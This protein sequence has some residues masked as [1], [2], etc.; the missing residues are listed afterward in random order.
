LGQIEAF[1]DNLVEL[2]MKDLGFSYRD[3]HQEITVMGERLRMCRNIEDLLRVRGPICE[4]NEE[5][6]LALSYNGSAWLNIVIATIFLAGNRVRVKFSSRG[7]DIAHF[8]ESLYHPIFGDEMIESLGLGDGGV[9]GRTCI[10]LK[11][12]TMRG[13]LG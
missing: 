7:P 5:A 1:R 9:A 2:A 8:L 3:N 4:E 11:S 12:L 10:S 6:A 13:I